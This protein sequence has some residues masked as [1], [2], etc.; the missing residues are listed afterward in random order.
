MSRWKMMFCK[1]QLIG[2]VGKGVQIA[3]W[4]KRV[5]LVT[6]QTPWKIMLPL[7]SIATGRRP[8]TVVGLVSSILQQWSLNLIQVIDLPPFFLSFGFSSNSEC[9]Y[10]WFVGFLFQVMAHASM[11]SLHEFIF[12]EEKI[13][14]CWWMYETEF[15]FTSNSSTPLI[16]NKNR[17]CKN[18][19]CEFQ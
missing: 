15:L 16:L 13:F 17:W 19:I 5:S 2:H 12:T 7:L 10:L 8:R 1:W 18:P 14:D 4:Y 6:Y 11:T 3:V 9:V